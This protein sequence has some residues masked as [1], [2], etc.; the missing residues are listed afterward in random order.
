[1]LLLGLPQLSD[2]LPEPLSRFLES[3]GTIRTA[4]ISFLYQN[5]WWSQD[6]VLY[7]SQIAG[8]D[9]ILSI[10]GN[11]YGIVLGS[12]RRGNRPH[13][14]LR[15]PNETWSY[16]N[17]YLRCVLSGAG[18]EAAENPFDLSALGSMTD[19]PHFAMKETLGQMSG[20]FTTVR[21]D[22]LELVTLRRDDTSVT[23]YI[24]PEKGYNA[25]RIVVETNGEVTKDARVSLRQY[26]G[27]WFPETIKFFDSAYAE[28]GAPV[29][30][31][32]VVSAE[33]NRP[34]HPQ[35]IAPADIGIE[36]GVVVEKPGY[37]G[38]LLVWDGA[39]P[40]P[41]S[42][43]LKRVESGELERGPHNRSA[44]A[45]LPKATRPWDAVADQDAKVLLVV[46]GDL[47]SD[48]EAYTRE[49]MKRY[50]LDDE[51]QRRALSL[52]R[53]CEARRATYLNRR[54]RELLAL[55]DKRHDAQ[56]DAVSRVDSDIK[57][58]ARPV[59][60]IF[61]EQLKPGLDTIPTPTQRNAVE[62][63]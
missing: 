1:M 26:D 32:D 59:Q 63:R 7:D 25:E 16:E 52:L 19:V 36:P 15:R 33:F 55:L 12:A 49:F 28:G 21:R 18:A 47:V 11:E 57:K 60:E 24:D 14:C 56:P 34:D 4:K 45:A 5:L 53:R 51:Q 40:V 54:R 6:S 37:R 31:L 48:W 3:R 30:V 2:P 38:E 35:S 9:R 17:D 27:V 62:D 23:W 44:L 61:E 13:T 8:T 41:L 22:G 50:S 20:Q 42:D 39:N 58:F 29:G 43:F 46:A 10:L